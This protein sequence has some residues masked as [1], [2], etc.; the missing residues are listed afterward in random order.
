[1]ND[2]IVIAHQ[3]VVRS[4]KEGQMWI[5]KG[6]DE[7]VELDYLREKIIEER[8]H[9]NLPFDKAIPYEAYKMLNE[10][11]AELR[12]QY[13][14]LLVL[15]EQRQRELALEA[16]HQKKEKKKAKLPPVLPKGTLPEEL[17]TPLGKTLF[18]KAINAQL[19][20]SK[21]QPYPETKT[22]ELRV[23][24]LAIS[25]EMGLNEYHALFYQL[26]GKVNV[27]YTKWRAGEAN[28]ATVERVAKLFSEATQNQI[29]EL[30]EAPL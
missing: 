4:H 13:D 16:E 3:F 27:K 7:G 23:L 30:Y 9:L 8:A 6:I 20:D 15:L 10:D 18:Q 29:K 25:I 22:V 19:I 28:Y 1:M 5:L 17:D 21:Y 2:K 24:S 14:N 11:F 26:W 12:E